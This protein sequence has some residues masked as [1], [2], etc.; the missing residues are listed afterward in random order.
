MR[1]LVVSAVAL[2]LLGAT[3]WG[4]DAD[5][6]GPPTIPADHPC[7]DAALAPAPPSLYVAA[8]A[9]GEPVPLALA[10]PLAPGTSA[11]VSQ[12]NDQ[13]PTHL[14]ADRWAWDFALPEE[15][16]VHAAAPGVVAY[17]RDDSTRFGADADY[18]GDANFVLVDHGGGLFTSY[19]HLAAASAVVAP[20]D[21]VFAGD[22][23]ARTGLSGQLT[24]PHLH[25]ALENAWSESL[26]AR[27]VDPDGGGC[28]LLPERDAVVTAGPHD[29]A[30][31]VVDGAPSAMPADAFAGSGVRALDG[32]PARL[33]EAGRAYTA[34][35]S[36]PGADAVWFLLIPPDGGTAVAALELP[37]KDGAFA[38]RVRWTAPPGRYGLGAVAVGPGDPIV[39]EATV[40]ITIE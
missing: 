11:R 5:V 20:G 26:P 35:G 23:L 3:D 21:P 27:F 15:S 28:D 32:L 8:E 13:L 37:V 12:G 16:P 9:S 24:G 40:R 1:R 22:L 7:P 33:F 34:R 31:L 39:V 36:A 10:L 4:C 6:G 18:R 2:V 14:G 19:V 17:V 38:G 30:A 25:F 29:G